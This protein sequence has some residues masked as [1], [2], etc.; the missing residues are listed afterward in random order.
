MAHP[1]LNLLQIATV[2]LRCR[3]STLPKFAPDV[4][5]PPVST[6]GALH[7][8]QG[9]PHDRHGHHHRAARRSARA[10]RTARRLLVTH[11][12]T[13]GGVH[14]AQP[15]SRQA[16]TPTPLPLPPCLDE[17][18]ASAP[19]ATRSTCQACDAPH[20]LHATPHEAQQTNEA[21]A[22][23]I[24]HASGRTCC[25]VSRIAFSACNAACSL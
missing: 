15:L 10:A 22:Q 16:D 2:T 6:S 25:N 14:R 13:P 11:T 19:A 23:N 4:L 18:S 24:A 21:T 17:H 12:T 20:A 9:H 3:P 1:C 5:S 8:T 7:S